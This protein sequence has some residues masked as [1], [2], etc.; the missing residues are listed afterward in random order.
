MKANH[1]PFL[2]TGFFSPLVCDYLKDEEQLRPYHSG[3]P[4]FDSLFKQAQ[5]KEKNFPASVRKSLCV[6]LREQYKGLEMGPAVTKNLELLADTKTLTVTTGHQL[7]LMTGPLY[8]IYKIISTLKLCRQLKD[9]FPEYNFVP[10]YWMASEDHDFEEIS[11]FVFKGKKFKWNNDCGGAV[12]KIPTSGLKPLLSLF[13]QELGDQVNAEALK[14]IISDSYEKATDLSEATRIFV[15]SLFKVYGLLILDG[16]HTALKK[17]FTPYVK[18]ELEHQACEK[19]VSEQIKE[20]KKTYNPQYKPQVNPRDVNL[21]LLE[22]GKRHRLMKGENGFTWEGNDSVLSGEKISKWLAVS[23]EKFS[24]NVLMRPL[25]QEVILPNIAYIGG[26]GEIAYWLELK[27]YFEYHNI[28]FP[29]LILRNS[30]LLIN[31]KNARKVEQLDLTLKDLFLNRNSLINKK[32]RQISNIDL[33]LTPFKKILATQFDALGAL[34]DQTDRSFEGAVKAQKVKQFKGIEHLEK[35]LLKAQKVKL[36]D[37]VERLVILHEQIFP[38]GNLQERVD[39]FSDYY[40]DHGSD[41][42]DFLMETFQPLS[43]EFSIIEG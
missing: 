43:K 38:G 42:F 36:K 21:F 34:V 37:Q 9:K 30:A 10:I 16:D 8:F 18:E 19:N 40:I 4:S 25:Y 29:L 27:S 3:V 2:E 22:E 15:H 23:P 33:D 41:L 24:P 32:V 26:G 20:L 31:P 17:Y 11:A 7:C 13:T 12:G 5:V 28:P 6:A 14:K 1:I 35:R 39:N